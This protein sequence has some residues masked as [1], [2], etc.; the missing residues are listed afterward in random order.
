[1]KPGR[2]NFKAGLPLKAPHEDGEDEEAS[3]KKCY[4]YFA[5]KKTDACS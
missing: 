4:L 3:V 5:F 2:N 1:M